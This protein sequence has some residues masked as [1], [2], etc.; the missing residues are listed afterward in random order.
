[1]AEEALPVGEAFNKLVE[2]TGQDPW[3]LTQQLYE[4]HAVGLTWYVFAGVGV[5]SAL[6]I[7]LYGRWIA[8]LA[9]RE[10]P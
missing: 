2:V 8:K 6:L 5:L 7:Y 4:T 1:M 10:T 9:Q 3:A